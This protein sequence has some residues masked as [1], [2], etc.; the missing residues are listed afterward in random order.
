MRTHRGYNDPPRDREKINQSVSIDR[1]E[2]KE[3]TVIV[4]EVESDNKTKEEIEKQ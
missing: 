3:K 1:E 4:Q 2:I